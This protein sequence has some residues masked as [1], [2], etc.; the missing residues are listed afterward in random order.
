M[1]KSKLIKKKKKWTNIGKK[2]FQSKFDVL[3]HSLRNDISLKR[4]FLLYIY[5]YIYIES[6]IKIRTF[7]GFDNKTRK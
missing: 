4:N 3:F 7:L 2:W 6:S 1:E 5:I